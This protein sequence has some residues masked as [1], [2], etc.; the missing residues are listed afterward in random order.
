MERRANIIAVTSGKGG[1]GKSTIA[2]N[3]GILFAKRGKRVCLVDGDY[4]LANINLL[5]GLPAKKQPSDLFEKSFNPHKAMIK[6]EWGLDLLPSASGI[7]QQQ[8]LL[9]PSSIQVKRLIEKLVFD[10]DVILID[11]SAGIGASVQN[12]LEVADQALLIINSEP[13]SLTDSF[14]L[15][16]NMRNVQ[17]SYNV[18]INRVKDEKTAK[19]IYKRFSVA[20]KKYIGVQV[21]RLG[22]I[23]EDSFVSA[24]ILSQSP[25]VIYSANCNASRCFSAIVK[26]LIGQLQR[27]NSGQKLESTESEDIISTD[28]VEIPEKPA[29]INSS[30][31]SF[32][33]WLLQMPSLLS[34]EH[35]RSSE[36]QSY[37]FKQRKEKFIS[38]L[39]DLCLSDQSILEYFENMVIGKRIKQEEISKLEDGK[40]KD[41]HLKNINNH[42]ND[43]NQRINTHP[44]ARSDKVVSLSDYVENKISM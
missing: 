1:V 35:V 11:T 26:N 13:T 44:G 42:L 25:L 40:L 7:S 18:I 22:Y 6:T 8:P 29:F 27:K 23:Q 15:I 12:Y 30:E 31:D 19:D 3:L 14:G 21:E 38:E 5:L 16:R 37:K 17:T 33:N 34:G 28:K 36:R 10:Y 41:S 24:A 43:L 20:V 4:G 39:G 2:V 9:A 32:E